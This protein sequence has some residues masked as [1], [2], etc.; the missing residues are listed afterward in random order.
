MDVPGNLMGECPQM[1]T[2]A[3]PGPQSAHPRAGSQRPPQAQAP[4]KAQATRTIKRHLA[5][6]RVVDVHGPAGDALSA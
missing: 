4:P 3:A 1:T 2:E 6:R 5:G